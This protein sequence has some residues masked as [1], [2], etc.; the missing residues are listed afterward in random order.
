LLEG[1]GMSATPRI[2]NFRAHEKNTL[3][4]FFD[5]QLG[6]LVIRGCML[7]QKGSRSW[8]SFPAKP[9]SNGGVETWCNIID[10]ADTD[11]R[12]RFQAMIVP[13]AV[14]ALE[15]RGAAA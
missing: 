5:L 3:R 13:L 8:V 2:L 1:D 6:G 11:A 12:K 10:F 7:H 14:E 15:Q 9:Y 4:G